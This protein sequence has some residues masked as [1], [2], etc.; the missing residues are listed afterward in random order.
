[1]YC[2]I[3]QIDE[4]CT[5][6]KDHVKKSIKSHCPVLSILSKTKEKK[7]FETFKQVNFSPFLASNSAP[8]VC[9][10]PYLL[11]ALGHG[12]NAL[13]FSTGFQVKYRYS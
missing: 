7:L 9:T 12:D 3:E 2:R 8:S 4:T 11:C 13:C 6:I 10:D 1:M 5:F